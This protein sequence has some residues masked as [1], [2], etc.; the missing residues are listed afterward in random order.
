MRYPTTAVPP[1][2]A[3]WEQNKAKEKAVGRF[4]LPTTCFLVK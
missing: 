2:D 3:S 4:K 1:R